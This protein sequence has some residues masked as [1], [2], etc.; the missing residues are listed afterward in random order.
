M[1]GWL[2]ICNPE[3][4][5]ASSFISS[6]RTFKQLPA[7]VLPYIALLNNTEKIQELL[8]QGMRRLG[9]QKVLLRIDSPGENYLVERELIALGAEI[10]STRIDSKQVRLIKE[11][12][13]RILYQREW[14]SGFRQFLG[15]LSY[16]ASEV[17]NALSIELDYMNTP[18][19]IV[20]M[21]HKGKTQK[22]LHKANIEV[23]K[24][25]PAATSYSELRE[26]MQGNGNNRIFIK[27]EGASSA[28]GVV[29][30]EVH[31]SGK[32]EQAT[33]TVDM[34]EA[35]DGLKLYNSLR[36]CR[37]RN[38]RQIRKLINALLQEGAHCEEWISK[39]RLAEH[40]FD[41]R[42]LVIDGQASHRVIRIS[43]TPFTNLH[44]GNKRGEL[45]ELRWG[46]AMW[47]RIEQVAE[48][49]AKVFND[50]LYVGVDLALPAGSR[51]PCVFES[52]AFGDLLPGLLYEGRD[53]YDKEILA[54]LSRHKSDS[55]ALGKAD[56]VF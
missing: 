32:M 44:L 52:N 48:K 22:L 19:D 5:R 33:T 35:K 18:E 28:S 47:S 29:A 42:V 53:T 25:L 1:L 26:L 10:E 7:Q 41:M 6:L 38:H 12:R 46:P 34:V 49:A 45:S 4:R 13:G 27:M 54:C 51:S 14:F 9:T 15:E 56:S 40:V 23:P 24:Y 31:P 39:E 3:N 11:E 43:D 50:S 37:Y 30:Y 55:Y 16:C 17:A 36:I 2:I 8:E 21:F 20:H